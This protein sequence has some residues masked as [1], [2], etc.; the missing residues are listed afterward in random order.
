MNPARS[1]APDLVLG[2]YS[3]FWVYVVGPLAG[4]ILAVALAHILRGPG[5]RDP[6]ASRAA[7]GA[8]ALKIRD[9]RAEADEARL[10]RPVALS[11][12]QREP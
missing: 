11:G 4:G 2:D 3:H 7:E 5:G 12:S 9:Q 1:F 8:P 10:H 6:L